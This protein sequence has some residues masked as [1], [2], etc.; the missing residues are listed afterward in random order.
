MAAQT[1]AAAWHARNRSAKISARCRA[2]L[3][4]VC[5]NATLGPQ[6]QLLEGC[7]VRLHMPLGYF[8]RA[9]INPRDAWSVVVA[10]GAQT[11][12]C[13]PSPLLERLIAALCIRPGL[14]EA[15]RTCR[16]TEF[17]SVDS[18]RDASPALKCSRYSP[19]CLQEQEE[20]VTDKTPLIEEG[21]KAA[22]KLSWIT[23][24]AFGAGSDSRHWLARIT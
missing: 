22:P 7:E 14:P 12:P 3:Y 15:D 23:R 2:P 11:R 5:T 6:L 10:R 24:F 21:A 1:T 9:N 17:R 13:M 18:S 8:R 16:S 19:R 20:L 4:D